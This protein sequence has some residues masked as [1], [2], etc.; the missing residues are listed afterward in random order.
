MPVSNFLVSVVE[1][2]RVTRPSFLPSSIISF[3]LF[4]EEKSVIIMMEIITVMSS[5]ETRLIVERSGGP[6]WPASPEQDQLFAER[7]SG[8][9]LSI[10]LS[11]ASHSALSDAHRT[12]LHSETFHKIKIYILDLGLANIAHFSQGLSPVYE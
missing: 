9:R 11:S 6:N 8:R 4:Y 10:V 5:S 2:D 12:V 3:W 7:H 1:M